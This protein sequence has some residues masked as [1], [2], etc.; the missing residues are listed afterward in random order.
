MN[1]DIDFQGIQFYWLQ[2][3]NQ[4]IERLLTLDEH[5]NI[6]VDFN[7]FWK[8]DYKTF[9]KNIFKISIFR[10]YKDRRLINLQRNYLNFIKKMNF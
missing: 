10:G 9:K 3:I 7:M 1:L 6:I 4:P 8:F 2:I 5:D